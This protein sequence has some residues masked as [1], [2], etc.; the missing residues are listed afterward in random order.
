MAVSK[1]FLSKLDDQW[2]KLFSYG[3]CAGNP[4]PEVYLRF[5]SYAIPRIEGEGLYIPKSW[6]SEVQCYRHVTKLFI[7]FLNYSVKGND[8]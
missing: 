2:C 6:S 4:D 3:I 5:K 8:I 7:D 1:L